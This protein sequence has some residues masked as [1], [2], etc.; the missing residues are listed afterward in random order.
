[1]NASVAKKDEKN[2]MGR[3]SKRFRYKNGEDLVNLRK[4][5]NLE[6]QFKFLGELPLIVARTFF[7]DEIMN[8]IKLLTTELGDGLLLEGISLTVDGF[9]LERILF[10][11]CFK[12]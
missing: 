6:T 10:Y 8:N 5:N 11:E 9:I 7:P 12:C 1:M 3:N 2:V 4:S